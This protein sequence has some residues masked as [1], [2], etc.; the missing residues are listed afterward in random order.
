M[1]NVLEFSMSSEYKFAWNTSARTLFYIFDNLTDC[2]ILY[3][4]KLAE[5]DYIFRKFGATNPDK[6]AF[7]KLDGKNLMLFHLD[8][9]K[10]STNKF[11]ELL[12][13]CLNNNIDIYIPIHQISSSQ[14]STSS[15]QS[16]IE[17]IN[18]ILDDYDVNRYNFKDISYN[19]TSEIQNSIIEVTKP[20]IREINLKKLLG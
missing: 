5:R 15:N 14:W 1:I 4:Y 8:V 9:Y 20:L 13:Y 16:H 11:R 19:K 2:M 3:R 7:D 12:D 6:I 10:E 18:D 17:S